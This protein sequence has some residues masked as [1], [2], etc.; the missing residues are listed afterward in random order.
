[1]DFLE[2]LGQTHFGDAT[3]FTDLLHGSIGGFEQKLRVFDLGYRQ[4]FVERNA[5]MMQ[6][7]AVH[8]PRT[9]V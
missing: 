2:V 3:A 8:M 5:V 9:H 4:L 1:M 6:K 7:H